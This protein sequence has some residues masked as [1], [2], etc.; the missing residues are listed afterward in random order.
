MITLLLYLCEYITMLNPNKLSIVW[1]MSDHT[2]DSEVSTLF[3][4]LPASFTEL[5]KGQ[6]LVVYGI[7]LSER[8][9]QL[10]I[11]FN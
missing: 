3:K 7:E 10:Q 6:D 9:K 2:F 5:F 8:T 11:L 1:Y 4:V